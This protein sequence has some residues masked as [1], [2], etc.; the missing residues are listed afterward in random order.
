MS[1]PALAQALR[2]RFDSLAMRAPQAAA[3]EAMQARRQPAAWR[4]LRQWCDVPSPPGSHMA[5]ASVCAAD[6][7]DTANQAL[8]AWVNAFARQQDGSL[9]LQAL[10]GPASR[11][12][13]RLQIKGQDML[14]ALGWRARQPQD[15]WDAGWAGSA[16]PSLRQ[17]PLFQP[18][19]A[20]L[21]L[22]LADEAELLQLP[23]ALL[24]QRSD[25]FGHPT[26]WLWVGQPA[27]TLPSGQGPALRLD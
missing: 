4:A 26:R 6:G 17:W 20:T 14:C 25:A 12:A 8:R 3:D 5:V 27:P 23:M 1:I 15:V 13:L 18:R 11:L 22:A 21:V 2:A 9:K 10:S 19:R 7:G 24:R 16:P